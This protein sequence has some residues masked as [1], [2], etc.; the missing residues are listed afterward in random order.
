MKLNNNS[1]FT[2]IE[3]LVVVAVSGILIIA[4]VNIFSSS[5]EIFNIIEKEN[6]VQQNFRFI[7][8]FVTEN[9]KYTDEVTLKDNFQNSISSGYKMIGQSGTEMKINN[10]N[11]VRTILDIKDSTTIYFKNE[12]GNPNTIT[13]YFN[14]QSTKIILNNCE[15]I[16]DDSSSK[17]SA[18]LFSK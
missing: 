2:L 7:T 6:E 5:F 18:I 10:N 11:N 1:G 13:L 14:D 15:N 9:I 8:D 4:V 16:I 12:N 17:A 3:I